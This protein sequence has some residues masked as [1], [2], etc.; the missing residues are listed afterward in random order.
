M[1]ATVLDISLALPTVEKAA[2]CRKTKLYKIV[3]Q[4]EEDIRR[5]LDKRFPEDDPET[6]EALAQLVFQKIGD[7]CRDK[8]RTEKTCSR[9]F[10]VLEN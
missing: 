6:L 9:L 1:L 10:S 8:L 7:F 5:D 3:K 4:L 2:K